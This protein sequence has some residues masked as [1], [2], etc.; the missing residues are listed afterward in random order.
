MATK[1][2]KCTEESVRRGR[3]GAQILELKRKERK[4]GERTTDSPMDTDSERMVNA[5]DLPKR[6]EV[7]T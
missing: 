7:R 5:L 6:N 3:R 2:A 4:E 1:D